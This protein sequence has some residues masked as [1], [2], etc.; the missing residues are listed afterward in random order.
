YA[1]WKV[2]LN[3]PDQSGALI[4]IG[5]VAMIGL[6]MLIHMLVN[7]GLIPTKGIALPFVSLGGS[8]ML[9]TAACIG[10]LLN[11]AA[12]ASPVVEGVPAVEGGQVV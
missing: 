12:Q 11:I 10:L 1:G 6:Q 3:A 8:S 7:V 9:V 4:A 5:V 2:I